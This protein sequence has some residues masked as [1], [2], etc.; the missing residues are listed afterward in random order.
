M[1]RHV[2]AVFLT[3]L[4]AA[5]AAAQIGSG[6][7]LGV[8]ARAMAF[9]NNHTAVANDLSAAYWNPAALAFLP[10]R[11]FQLSFDAFRI[12]SLSEIEGRFINV[13]PSARMGDDRDRIRL[14]SAGAMTAIPT[15]QGGL[16]IAASFDRPY[17]FDD[18]TVYTYRY[19]D[20]EDSAS[21]HNKGGRSGDLNRWSGA[22]GIQVAP[23]IAAGLSLSLITGT[24][25]A[26]L[27]KETWY[28]N[29]LPEDWSEYSDPRLWEYYDGEDNS[30]YMGY[31]VSLGALY[32]PL[33]ILK[34]GVKVNALSNV[35][36]SVTSANTGDPDS[37]MSK[38]RAVKY[39]AY[40]AP[41]GA[42]GAGLVLPWL[43]AALDLR[44]TLPYTFIMGTEDIPD[45]VQARYF[46]FGAGI[47]LEAPLPAFP[48][49]LRA[50]Y[51]FD[52]YDLYPM[53][54]K[55]EGFPIDWDDDMGRGA[56]PGKNRQTLTAGVGVFT[57]GTGIELSYAFQTWGIDIAYNDGNRGI[58]YKQNYTSHR[59]MAA[60]IYRY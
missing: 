40:T 41:S 10:V 24:E 56:W 15:L 25:K 29:P 2:F 49:V 13:S 34:L 19:F 48:V 30:K 35:G 36:V 55:Y 22:F 33:D 7:E 53:I 52:E 44:L 9:A 6:V 38:N 16:T 43:T 60:L 42:I 32:Y 26:P 12:G 27:R 58:S 4:F 20:G 31:A 5:S 18:F 45:D 8:G 11:E 1:R 46:K 39:R 50:G 14:S 28:D 57:S 51:S 17:I 54:I 21:I 59:V 37:P 47:G 3:L 23:K